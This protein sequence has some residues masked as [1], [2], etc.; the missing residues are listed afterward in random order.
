MQKLA[1]VVILYN[2]PEDV[3]D[4]IMTYYPYLDFLY[5]LDNSEKINN[6]LIAKIRELHKAQ[7]IC[8]HDN[9]GIS[10]SLNEALRLSQNKFNWLLT[11]DQDSS[12]KE[13]T[14]SNYIQCIDLLSNNVYGL[15]S[16]IFLPPKGETIKG[17]LQ[18]VESCITS[19]NIIN[20]DIAIKAGGFDERL[21]IDEVD[22]EFCYR[23]NKMGF[24]LIRYNKSIMN[25]KVGTPLYGSILGRKFITENHSYVRAYYIFRNCLYVSSRYPQKRLFYYNI[26]IRRFIKLLLAGTG[27]KKKCLY[28]LKGI[29][30]YKRG[31]VGKL[32]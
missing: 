20:I 28:I 15:T 9:L 11:M 12:F 7:Y 22:N 6:Q 29:L 1:G 14:F 25:H 23:C 18:N 19:G 30:D 27:K 5:I 13:N 31:V 16:L 2:P 24:K 21:F 26:L 10:Y 32:K 8:H 17:T 4:N 3:F